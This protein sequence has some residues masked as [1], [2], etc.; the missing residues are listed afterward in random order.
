MI[1]A[2]GLYI[3]LAYPLFA[4]VHQNPSIGRLLLM[5]VVLC[6]L[7]GTF[8]DHSRRRSR[9]Q[10]PTRIRSRPVPS[11]SQRGFCSVGQVHGL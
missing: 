7:H 10:F 9:K 5:Q 4:W 1:G 3:S 11:S 8:W 6:T 2:Y